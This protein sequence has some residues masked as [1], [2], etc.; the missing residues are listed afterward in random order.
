MESSAGGGCAR[1][2][3]GRTGSRWLLIKRRGQVEWSGQ[4]LIAGDG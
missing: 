2:P 4:G 1:E 3:R